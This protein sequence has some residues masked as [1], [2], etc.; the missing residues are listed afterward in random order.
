M[1][2]LGSAA[3]TRVLLVAA[4]LTLSA[5]GF[6]LAGTA[7]MPESLG[8]IKLST[9]GFADLQRQ[10]LVTRLQQAGATIVESQQ[11]E[12]PTLVVRLGPLR[13]FSLFQTGEVEQTKRLV[14]EMSYQ[15]NA[16]SGAVLQAE[17]RLR[18]ESTHEVDL[19]NILAT[20]REK[21]ELQEQMQNVLVSRMLY[22]LQ[23]M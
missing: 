22:Q 17:R 10:Q 19:L 9:A 23:R 1:R 3:V 15:V 13:E 21:A 5:C 6:R 11:A 14:Q 18:Q 2:R 16:A 12:L 7:V 20:E 8:Q 4:V